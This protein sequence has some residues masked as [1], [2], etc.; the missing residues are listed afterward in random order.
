MLKSNGVD[1]VPGF[2]A[3]IVAG[4]ISVLAGPKPGRTSEKVAFDD[5]VTSSGLRTVRSRNR[6]SV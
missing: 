2:D 5:A 6:N 4:L 3:A 1:N